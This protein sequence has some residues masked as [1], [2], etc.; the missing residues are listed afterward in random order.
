MRSLKPILLF[1]LLTILS[2]NSLEAQL[3]K[4]LKKRVQEATEDVIAEKAAQKVAQESGKALDS[5]LEIDPDYQAK[6]PEHMAQMM[7]AG[8]EN[9]P[10]ED[11]YTFNTMVIYEMTITDGDN[12]SE[13]NYEMWF[14]ENA[15]Y[16]ATQVNN[17]AQP[18]PKDMP[19][20]I[21]SILDD[22]NQAMI[23]VMEEQKMAQLLS[24]SKIKNS[25]IAESEEEETD[26]AFEALTKTGN[27]KQILG[28]T[29]EE[30]VSENESG[31]LSFW[32]TTELTLF[33]KNM[34]FN[35]SQSLG[36]NTFGEIPSE[37]RGFMM[38][39]NYE[40]LSSKEKSKMQ[41]V[42]IKN[43]T[44]EINMMEYQRMNLGQFMQK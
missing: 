36:G 11:S 18:D 13:V 22:K 43:E 37:A 41:V 7:A 39:M 9:I 31:K 15:P 25:A 34:F 32:V 1:S 35:M 8:S 44:K 6:Y 5:L 26:T 4:K 21:L 2:T 12:S 24:M 10:I 3:L 40:D 20:A 28:Y 27:S 42:D 29:C 33:Q 38:E 14:S 17:N 16:M 30:F 19:S 23:I